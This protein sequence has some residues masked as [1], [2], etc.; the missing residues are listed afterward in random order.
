MWAKVAATCVIF[1]GFVALF[2]SAPVRLKRAIVVAL[3]FL[4]GLYFFLS[5]MLPEPI[6]EGVL[7]GGAHR[8]LVAEQF[9]II[10]AFSL[11]LGLLSVAR[12]HG[13]NIARRRPGWPFSVV[14]FLSLLTMLAVGF[15]KIYSHGRVKE[16][17][18]DLFDKVLFDKALAPLGSTVFSL[19]AFFIASAAYRAFRV[20]TTEATLMMAAAVLV[21]LGQ[22]PLGGLIS[23]GVSGA[24]GA[25][26]GVGPWLSKH[27]LTPDLIPHIK[28]WLLMVLNAAAQRGIDFGVAVGAMAMSL[29]VWLSLERGMFIE[30]R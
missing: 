30:G 24:V 26:P 22:V 20:R 7:K 10:G 25:V 27:V 28:D 18:T 9:M 8:D 13:E 16:V 19:L 5:F 29:R 11:G 14:L 4:A 6:W 23:K 21:M 12:V 15:G 1:F 2:H 3:T 17:L